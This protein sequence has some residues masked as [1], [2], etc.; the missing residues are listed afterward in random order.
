MAKKIVFLV[1]DDQVFRQMLWD[2]FEDDD[3]I[4]L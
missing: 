4:M 1:D 3:R 2:V